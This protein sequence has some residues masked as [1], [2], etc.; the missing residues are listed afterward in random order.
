MI[1]QRKFGTTLVRQLG[2][3]GVLES[4]LLAF[5][6][7]GT[8][9]SIPRNMIFGMIICLETNVPLGVKWDEQYFLE[10]LSRTFLPFFFMV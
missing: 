10:T 4:V 8:R 1:C 3:E 7:S 2:L 5:L 6:I 9:N